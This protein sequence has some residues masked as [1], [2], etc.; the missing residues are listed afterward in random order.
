MICQVRL[1]PSLSSTVTSRLPLRF[2][3]SAGS[4]NGPGDTRV[5]YSSRPFW[6]TVTW[7]L[8]LAMPLTCGA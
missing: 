2:W 6:V 3:L 8:L 1:V 5:W 7:A 4:T